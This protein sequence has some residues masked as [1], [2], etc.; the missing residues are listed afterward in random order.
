MDSVLVAN[1]VWEEVKRRNT[2][3]VFFKVDYEKAYDSVMWNFIYYM[4]ERLDFCGRWIK[5]IRA[6]LESSSVSLLVNGSPTGEFKP[7][8]GLRQGDPLTPFLFLIVTE[9]L[10]VV[11]RKAVEKDLLESLEIGDRSIKVNMPQ[12]ADD[13]F[14]FV[15]RKWKACSSS[16]LF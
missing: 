2:S 13:T 15:K 5:W 8:K 1:E 7:L 16:R 3:C 14:F 4:M 11:V 9:G 12:Y 6:C 10:T